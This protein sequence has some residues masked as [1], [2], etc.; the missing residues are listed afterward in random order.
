MK[1]GP[2]EWHKDMADADGGHYRVAFA[3]CKPTLEALARASDDNDILPNS[4]TRTHS[5]LN[6]N[7]DTAVTDGTADTRDTRHLLDELHAAL[8]AKA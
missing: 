5:F 3:A 6:S 2:S 1:V 8:Y 4:A 7:L